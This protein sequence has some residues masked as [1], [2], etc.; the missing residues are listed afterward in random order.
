MSAAA[1][2]GWLSAHLFHQG[3]L[4]VLVADVVA[5]VVTEATRAGLADGH[6]F[7]RYWEGGLHVRLRLRPN[8]AEHV[9]PLRTLIRDRAEKYFAGHPSVPRFT[10]EEY[11]RFA[12]TLARGERLDRYEAEPRPNDSVQ[13]VAYRPEY[14]AYGDGAAMTAVERHFTGSSEVAL[15]VLATG[16]AP[17]RRAA[18]ALAATLATLAVCEPDLPSA[19]ARLA[20]ALAGTTTSGGLTGSVALGGTTTSG[21]LT[22]SVALDP[23]R[24]ASEVIFQR[25]RAG[26][27][28]QAR[29]CWTGTAG[30]GSGILAEWSRSIRELHDTL[31]AL[32]ATGRH[33]PPD[34]GSP[35]GPLAA[36]ASPDR[37]TVALVLLR[38]AHLLNNRLGLGLE[39]EAQIGLV[40]ARTLASLSEVER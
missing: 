26:L 25:D 2:R 10:A 19:A 13:F 6:F 18:V 4:D 30:S 35:M 20:A 7:L 40:A 14:H 37:R 9:E 8:R 29:A 5:P 28:R 17:P 11:R 23:L 21:G 12:A 32:W 15:R 34:P 36:V 1:D 24:A 3:D 16:A 33:V 39:A 31:T 38:C 27:R 22:G